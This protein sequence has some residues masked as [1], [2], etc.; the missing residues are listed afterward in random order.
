MNQYLNLSRKWRPKEL[1]SVI[2]Q[3]L[4]INI[5]KNSLYKN[6]IF[7]VY[8]FSGPKGSGKTTTARLF[9]SALNCFK[10]KDF[11]K[12]PKSISLPCN[13]CN[14]CLAMLKSAHPDFIE[15][16]A[17]SNTGVENIRNI[18]ENSSFSPVLADKKIYLIDEAHMLSKSAFNAFLKILEEP[19]KNVIF[20]LVTTDILKIIAT[21]RS[22]SFQLFFEPIKTVKVVSYLEFICE[23]E[24]IKCNKDALDL[25]AEYSE[26]SLRDGLNL[27]EKLK[28]S[29]KIIDKN[30]VLENL[31]FISSET[32]IELIEIILDNNLNALLD[33]FKLVNFKNYNALNIFKQFLD[34]VYNLFL[35]ENNIEIKFNSINK[36]ID[37]NRLINILD[38]CSSYEFNIVKSSMPYL[39]L[40]LMFIKLIE[41]NSK[42][43][44]V[45]KI[46]LTENSNIVDKIDNNVDNRLKDLLKEINNLS[47][48]ILISIFNQAKIEISSKNINLIFSKDFIFFKDLVEDTKNLWIPI[49]NKIFGENIIVNF[50]FNIDKNIEK[51]PDLKKNNVDIADKSKWPK[52]N[53]IINIFNGKVSWE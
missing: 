41:N 15:V 35:K 4:V 10:L 38:I 26:G 16:D 27:I 21:V 25:I 3:D 12:N 17:A 23:K 30:L 14:S 50:E 5:I 42:K 37:P 31:G 1:D 46:K 13:N 24:N 7:P 45:D 11:I 20:M 32:L 43:N 33:F 44:I 52:T 40:E 2:G 34:L 18:I 28:L 29:D 36:K 39:N 49:F 53:N 51:K 6:L 19:P 9:S 8:L 47:D 22:R 48:P